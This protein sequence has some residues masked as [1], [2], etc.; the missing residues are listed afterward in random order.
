MDSI[1]SGRQVGKTA[2]QI[3]ALEQNPQAI[4]LCP[5]EER[6]YALRQQYPHIP[7]E[8]FVWE[9]K[10]EGDPAPTPKWMERYL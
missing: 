5:S 6:R 9:P 2:A 1:V 7:P 4:M 8:Q 10:P 3:K